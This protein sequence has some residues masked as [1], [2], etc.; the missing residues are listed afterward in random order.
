[1]TR[2]SW[3]F[4]HVI[5]VY[6]LVISSTAQSRRLRLELIVVHM[7]YFNVIL[8]VLGQCDFIK[9]RKCKPEH[10]WV[11]AEKAVALGPGTPNTVGNWDLARELS[12]S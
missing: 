8:T 7:S 6:K 10:E 5:F 2:T 4:W 3:P 12:A 11:G 9:Y 1:M